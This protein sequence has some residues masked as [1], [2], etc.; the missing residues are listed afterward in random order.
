VSNYLAWLNENFKEV[1][2]YKKIEALDNQDKRELEELNR[3]ESNQF[4][5][6]LEIKYPE[7]V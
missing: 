2:E 6:W 7:C 1:L 5:D 3:D 4:W